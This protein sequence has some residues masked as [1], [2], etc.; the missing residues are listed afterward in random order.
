MRAG[1]PPGPQAP[2]RSSQYGSVK[3]GQTITLR[4]NTDQQAIG[5]MNDASHGIRRVVTRATPK[6]ARST[7]TPIQ[8]STLVVPSP[9]TNSP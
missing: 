8:R 7:P 1:T 2:R 5:D 9:G 4:R 6:N 3:N